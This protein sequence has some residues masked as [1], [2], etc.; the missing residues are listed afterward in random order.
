MRGP[1]ELCINDDVSFLEELL[2]KDNS[3]TTHVRN[4][5]VIYIY[6][7]IYINGLSP[8]IMKLVFPLKK[9]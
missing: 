5:Q 3:F 1:S 2:T 6:I 7:Y 9:T 4:T 8:E